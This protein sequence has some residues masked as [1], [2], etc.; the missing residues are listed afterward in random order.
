M[1]GVIAVLIAGL[2][3]VL[4][5]ALARI[6]MAGLFDVLMYGLTRVLMEV[7]DMAHV[8]NWQ[9]DPDWEGPGVGGWWDENMPDSDQHGLL[10]GEWVEMLAEQ[11]IHPPK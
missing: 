11:G 4:I 6:L 5:A 3:A 9:W 1:A 10:A 2:V 8:P 7:F